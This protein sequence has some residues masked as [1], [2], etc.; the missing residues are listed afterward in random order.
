M[1]INKVKFVPEKGSGKHKAIYKWAGKK[2]LL[3]DDVVSNLEYLDILLHNTEAKTIWANN[4]LKAL[5]LYKNETDIDIIIMDLQMPI[6]DGYQATRLIKEINPKVPIIIQTAF[7]EISN[8]ELA[9]ESGCDYYLQKPIKPN[10][11]LETIDKYL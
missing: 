4:G 6:M 5:E 1:P 2:I 10:E 7:N 9:F 3:V 8:K 11:L